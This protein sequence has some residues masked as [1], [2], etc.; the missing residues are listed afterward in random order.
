[1]GKAPL[2][3]AA[4]Q[5]RVDSSTFSVSMWRLLGL[6]A[7]LF[8]VLF[9][10]ETMREICESTEEV[11]NFFGEL[12]LDEVETSLLECISQGPFQRSTDH[13]VAVV[14]NKRGAN[15]SVQFATWGILNSGLPD[16]PHNSTE[17]QHEQDPALVVVS[18]QRK[19]TRFLASCSNTVPIRC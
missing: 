6:V 5:N 15:F 16:Q 13:C 3:D 4:E 11:C 18:L 1:M 14:V 9:C 2:L 10:K 19:R 7:G 12:V 8:V 17:S